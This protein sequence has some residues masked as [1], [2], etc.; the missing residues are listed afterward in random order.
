MKELDAFKGDFLPFP[1]LEEAVK[2]DVTF[3]KGS[4]FDSGEGED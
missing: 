4:K 1:E 3:L 2:Q